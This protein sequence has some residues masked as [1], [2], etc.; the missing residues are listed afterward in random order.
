MLYKVEGTMNKINL[1]SRR[2]EIVEIIRDH[3][4][5]SFDFIARRFRAVP[6]R[7]LHYDIS[8]LVRFGYV[9]KLGNTRGAMYTMVESI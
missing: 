6:T 5:V 9:K 2:A 7:T 1:L 3:K 8:Q 4:M